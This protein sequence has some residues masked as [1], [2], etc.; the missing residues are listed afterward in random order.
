[1]IRLNLYA[2]Y[3]RDAIL[4]GEKTIE[5]RALNPEEPHRYFGDIQI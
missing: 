4:S 5:T 1:M 3:I 2:Q